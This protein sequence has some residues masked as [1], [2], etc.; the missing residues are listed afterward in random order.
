[1]EPDLDALLTYLER[2]G[3]LAVLAFI[4]VTGMKQVWVWGWMYRHALAE[5]DE[6]K[7]RWLQAI[8]LA[9]KAVEK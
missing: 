4:I 1:M 2:G 6:W 7:N 9:E 8:K 5:R 3:V